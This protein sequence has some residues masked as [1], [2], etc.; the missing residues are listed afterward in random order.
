MRHPH[1]HIEDAV[2]SVITLLII[3]A[4]V[5]F[6]RFVMLLVLGFGF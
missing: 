6:I 3:R 2:T 4:F 5:L 1:R